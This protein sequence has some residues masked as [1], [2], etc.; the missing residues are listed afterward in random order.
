MSAKTVKQTFS[1]AVGSIGYGRYLS[2]PLFGGTMPLV[3]QGRARNGQNKPRLGGAFHLC[4][5]GGAF[6][7]C[8]LGGAFHLFRLG[9]LSHDGGA[10]SAI[11]QRSN[12]TIL[13]GYEIFN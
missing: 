7:L 2:V 6:H 8:R 4:R 9:G 5:L 11:I 12:I 1:G 13:S 10:E 3:K